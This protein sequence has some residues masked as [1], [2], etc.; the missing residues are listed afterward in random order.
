MVIFG[1]TKS[2]VLKHYLTFYNRLDSFVLHPTISLFL[3]KKLSSYFFGNNIYNVML[4]SDL[5]YT[6]LVHRQY[7]FIR[8]GQMYVLT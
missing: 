7:R 6:A 2:N 3:I 8:N 1:S 4:Y 5:V